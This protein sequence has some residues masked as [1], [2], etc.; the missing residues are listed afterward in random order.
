[1]ANNEAECKCGIP[2]CPGHHRI[3]NG[4]VQVNGHPL[5]A[6][7]TPRPE[8]M[9]MYSKMLLDGVKRANEKEE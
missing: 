9:K 3:V 8:L 2:N 6:S 1:M 4:K 7:V 5:R